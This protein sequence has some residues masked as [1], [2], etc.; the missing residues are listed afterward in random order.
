MVEKDSISSAISERPDMSQVVASAL[1]ATFHFCFI[2]SLPSQIWQPE[3]G[4]DRFFLFF[5]YIFSVL[6]FCVLEAT[7]FF[8]E[9]TFAVSGAQPELTKFQ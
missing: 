6:F 8:F 2:P 9:Q 1:G 3:I 5:I 7:L 4:A